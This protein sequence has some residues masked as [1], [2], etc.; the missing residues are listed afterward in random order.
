M[1]LL[2]TAAPAAAQQARPSVLAIDTVAEAD[3]TTDNNGN[4]TKGVFLDS[5]VVADFGKNV[6]AMVRPQVQR[7]AGSGEWNN[8]IWVAEL[9]YER[10]GPI[11]V[12]AEGGYIPSPVGLANLTLRPQLNPTIGLPAEL[13]TSI[14]SLEVRGPR[15]NLLSGIYPLGAQG[16]VSATH[17]D[18]RVAIIDTSPLRLRRVFANPN[19]PLFAGNPP[20]FTNV[21]FGGGITPF[22][23]FRIGATVTRGGW[24]KT[25]E[26]AS[27]VDRSATLVDIETELSFR[28]TSLAGEWVHDALDTTLGMRSASGWYVQGAQNLTPRLFVAG[29]YDSISTILPLTTDPTLD[30]RNTEQTLGYRLTTELTLRASHRM[31]QAFGRTTWDHFEAVSVVWY[32]RWM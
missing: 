25:G 1:A 7:L 23:G 31:R 18:A 29:R 11:A 26:S 15:I 16:T 21:V 17:W 2:M 8:Q 5:L 9:R 30:F 14:P 24:L 10:Q 28:H 22:V 32:R 4:E 27:L 20:R 3:V 13:F 12:R 6:A 19:P